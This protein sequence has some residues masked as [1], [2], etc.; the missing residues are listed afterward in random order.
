MNRNVKLQLHAYAHSTCWL[1][2]LIQFLT[3]PTG[4]IKLSRGG[5]RNISF[6]SRSRLHGLC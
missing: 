6:A 5:W 2:N 1:R 3:L 4:T